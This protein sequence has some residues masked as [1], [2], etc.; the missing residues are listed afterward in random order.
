MFVKSQI[1]DKP[2]IMYNN[3]PLEIVESSFKS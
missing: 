2:H 3:E 1:K